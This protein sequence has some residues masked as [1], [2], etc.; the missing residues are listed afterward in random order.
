MNTKFTIHKKEE[1]GSMKQLEK[2]MYAEPKFMIPPE[3]S[4]LPKPFAKTL[5]KKLHEEK[6]K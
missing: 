4:K 6:L 3:I 1:K 2:Q 5:E